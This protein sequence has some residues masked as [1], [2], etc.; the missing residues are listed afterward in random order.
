MGTNQKKIFRKIVE[1][2]LSQGNPQLSPCGPVHFLCAALDKGL[3][4]ISWEM[5]LR[6]NLLLGEPFPH[7]REDFCFTGG[8]SSACSYLRGVH[9]A[10]G[11]G[12]GHRRDIAQRQSPDTIR[13]RAEDPGR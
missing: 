1:G 4:S 2:G 8:K 6:T 9:N 12:C 5:K 11:E 10:S 13:N 3:Y 7:E